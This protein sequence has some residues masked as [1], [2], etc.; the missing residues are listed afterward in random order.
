ML[1]F[2]IKNLKYVVEWWEDDCLDIDGLTQTRL[3]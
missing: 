1:N 3:Q 2:D